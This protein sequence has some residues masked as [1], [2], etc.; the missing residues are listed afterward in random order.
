MQ[1][2]FNHISR[3]TNSTIMSVLYGKRCPR[4]ESHEATAFYEVNHLWNSIL[5]AGAHPPVDLLPFLKYIPEKWAT[6]K[7]LAK[8]I[9]RK[10]RDLYFGL[11]TETERRMKWGEENGSYTEQVL[12]RQE[13][14]RLDREMVG[15]LQTHRIRPVAPLHIPHA[16]TTDEKVMSTCSSLPNVD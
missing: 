11:V 1:R 2:F 5:E 4:Y 14:L 13:E 7:Q 16:T 8:L 3:S 9:R 15:L 10:Q 6:W 12:S